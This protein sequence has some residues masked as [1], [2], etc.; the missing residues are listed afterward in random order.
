MSSWHIN[1]TFC[2]LL[3]CNLAGDAPAPAHATAQL[4]VSV[5]NTAH[6]VGSVPS[7]QE[8][9]CASNR[10][11]CSVPREV[12]RSQSGWSHDRHAC[13]TPGQRRRRAGAAW[14]VELS[15]RAHSAGL[16]STPHRNNHLLPRSG[17]PAGLNDG[18]RRA[19][20]VFEKW[21][22]GRAGPSQGSELISSTH[23]NGGALPQE[24]ACRG[25]GTRLLPACRTS[26]PVRVLA[27]PVPAAVATQEGRPTASPAVRPDPPRSTRTEPGRGACFYGLRCVY[28][29]KARCARK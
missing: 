22:T 26:M 12:T 8:P 13:L 1:V 21:C 3:R 18:E 10:E 27:G 23:R 17:G 9:S 16:A 28:S 11:Q 25:C 2:S 15:R 29:L 20:H 4:V 19:L 7:Q 5:A 14:L 6:P 24:K